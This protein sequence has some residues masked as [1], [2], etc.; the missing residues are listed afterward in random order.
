MGGFF[1]AKQHVCMMFAIWCVTHSSASSCRLA[2]TDRNSPEPISD[3][4]VEQASCARR[5][6]LV[7]LNLSKRT[8]S[9]S[10]PDC[11]D[12]EEFRR[13]ELP[14]D[15]CLRPACPSSGPNTAEELLGRPDAELDDQRQTAALALC[16]LSIASSAAFLSGADQPAEHCTDVEERSSGSKTRD[17]TKAQTTS[18]KR[19][20]SDQSKNHGTKNNKR[21][22]IP[23]R[24]LRR[25]PRCC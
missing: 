7:P 23:E 4:S 11:S 16:Q 2:E 22:K 19:A 17:T 21:A 12:G 10:K 6:E 13:E 5:E 15:L 25:R 8:Q 20:N 24:R 14:L 1:C 9:D 18:F 3:T